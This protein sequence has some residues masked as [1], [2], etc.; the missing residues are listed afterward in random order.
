M[1]NSSQITTLN[2]AFAPFI[3]RVARLRTLVVRSAVRN[4]L[5]TLYPR[6][7]D[8]VMV[9]TQCRLIRRARNASGETMEGGDETH[10]ADRSENGEFSNF[11][12]EQGA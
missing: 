7:N 11:R 5:K 1:Q 2:I 9:D 8:H 4:L 3:I 10:N 12:D 6:A